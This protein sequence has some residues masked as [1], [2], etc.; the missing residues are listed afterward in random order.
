MKN[1]LWIIAVLMASSS[2]LAIADDGVRGA[3]ARHHAYKKYVR[4]NTSP[5]ATATHTPD[6]G[7]LAAQQAQYDFARTAPAGFVSGD[8]LGS[9]AQQALSLPQTG[10]TWQE[11][12]RIPYNAEPSGYTD[13]FWSNI[14]AGFSI[15]GGR[16]TALVTTGHGEWFAGAADGGVW[17]SND[18][19]QN[20]T[21]VFDS[22]PTLSIGALAADPR[23][24]SLWVGT[25]EANTSQDSYSGTGVYTSTNHGN[26]WRRVGDDSS[27]NNVLASHTVFR[28]AFDRTGNAYAATNNG[29]FRLAA[30]SD[31]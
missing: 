20:W 2:S 16:V 31:S 3:G 4:E 12:T 11:F 27:G 13:P 7:D 19:G 1:Y 6:D 14:G 9:A 8:A 23:D 21:A 25:G 26:S 30:G 18:Q 15:V 28:I 5:A 24:G 29:L 10:G 22:M 17:R